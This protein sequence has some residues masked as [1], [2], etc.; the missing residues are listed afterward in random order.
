MPPGPF[1]GTSGIEFKTETDRDLFLALHNANIT[2]TGVK[3]AD[4]TFTLVI[5]IV[6]TYN[7]ESQVV[8]P[9][10]YYGGYYYGGYYYDGSYSSGYKG[11]FT[12]I[13]NELAVAEEL[14]TGI[15]PFKVTVMIKENG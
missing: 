2:Y 9:G 5:N 15:N 13:I 14:L 4:G 12:A 1:S 10:N 7:F 11:A 8:K 6:D 3:N